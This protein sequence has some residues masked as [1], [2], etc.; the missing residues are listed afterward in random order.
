[1]SRDLTSQLFPPGYQRSGKPD[2]SSP[3]P[4]LSYPSSRDHVQLPG[5]Q[6]PSEK[7]SSSQSSL[8]PAGSTNLG[9]GNAGPVSKSYPSS[10]DNSYHWRIPAASRVALGFYMVKGLLTLTR[11]AVNQ[12]LK[13]L[14]VG[15]G[16]CVM[17]AVMLLWLSVVMTISMVWVVSLTIF[18][19]PRM[20]AMVVCMFPRVK[21]TI[22]LSVVHMTV[23]QDC[24][25]AISMAQMLA[26][27]TQELR[28]GKMV[29]LQPL[30][31]VST[32]VWVFMK[33][34]ICQVLKALDTLT[35]V[36]WM[37]AVAMSL[38]SLAKG[39]GRRALSQFL[40]MCLIWS[41][42]PHSALAQAT[43][44]EELSSPKLLTRLERSSHRITW[45]STPAVRVQNNL[46]K[47]ATKDKTGPTFS[48]GLR[49]LS[50]IDL[51]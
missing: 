35:M 34:L 14:A 45:Q 2:S 44:E 22:P 40:V 42:S 13:N 9:M 24:S 16:L 30:M 31:Q 12:V 5:S 17:R 29:A 25:K 15:M 47:V 19:H 20:K 33:S 36:L 48:S 37:E 18:L 7:L 43:N 1:M 10:S 46:L 51:E 6:N 39:T 41:Q 28:K 50:A 49:S 32:A 26:A 27:A 38:R 23:R 3:L 11:L 8:R 4:A 21:A